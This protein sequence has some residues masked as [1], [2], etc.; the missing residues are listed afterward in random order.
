MIGR[1]D[2][3]RLFIVAAATL[4]AAGPSGSFAAGFARSGGGAPRAARPISRPAGLVRP[5]MHGNRHEPGDGHRRREDRRGNYVNG[6]WWPYGYSW[7]DYSSDVY[8]GAEAGPAYA[9]P[10]APVAEATPPCPELVHWSAK[11]GKAVR[12][13]LCDDPGAA[14]S[15][16]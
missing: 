10:P 5:A 9:E 16:E 13:R 2:C 3:R 15:T 4:F 14:S 1:A 12:Y 8:Y 11:L 6:Y 7:P